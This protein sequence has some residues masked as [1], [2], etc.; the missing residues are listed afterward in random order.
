MPDRK[1]NLAKSIPL[2][3]NGKPGI[4]KSIEQMYPASCSVEMPKQVSKKLNNKAYT[5]Q[6]KETLAATFK[7][8]V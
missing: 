4:M 5:R 8:R 6:A 7:N 2:V 3:I 1:S